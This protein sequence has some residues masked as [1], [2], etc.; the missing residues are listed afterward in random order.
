MQMAPLALAGLAT[1][2]LG[3]VL[4]LIL[5][6]LSAYAWGILAVGAA[7]LG[8]AVIL[9]F[10]RVKGALSSRRGR[11]SVGT[12]V[13]ASLFAGIILVAN[14]IS[15][16][17]Y[18]RFDFTSLAQFTLT[19]Q[20]KDVLAG[21]DKPVEVV[22]FFGS[23]VPAPVSSYARNLLAEYQNYSDRLT[24]RDVDPDLNPDQARQYQVDQ[25]GVQYGAAVFR[26]EG[27]QRQVYGP[28]ISGEAEHAFT[29][30]ILEVTGTR[31]KKVYFLTGHGEG[32]IGSTLDSARSGLRDDLFQVDTLDLLRTPGIPSDAA[33]LVVAGPR[34]PLTAGELSTLQG[35]LR[36]GGRMLLLMDPGAPQ[37]FRQLLAEWG[38]QFLDGSIVD[39]ASHVAP[40]PQTVLVSRTQNYFGLPQTYFPG[41]A[42]LQP[43]E[44]AREGVSVIPL[45]WSS[46]S[47]WIDRTV[48]SGVQPTFD[49]ATDLMGPW[50]VGALVSTG[51][52]DETS[53]PDG[54]R[55][56]VFSDSDFISNQHYRN[57]SNSG[58]FLTTMNWLA[59]GKEVV[60][61]D[62]KVLP[63]RPLVLNP[64]Q[65][66]F[67]LISSIGL[68]PLILLLAAGWIAWRRR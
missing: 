37:G 14:A 31:Q 23:T 64:E 26:S 68:L 34:G 45:V 44:E 56:A 40:N 43:T 16:G 62:R 47:S 8:A 60:S 49:A 29:S 28:Q 17:T 22:T 3:F 7:L 1:L 5:P 24:V 21:L 67:L 53:V 58:L 66:R 36:E 9:D 50:A 41:A 46:R 27:G 33:V 6:G 11:F 38:M 52:A 13:K 20:T 63:I 59:T 19:S 48:P 42:A 57:E 35:Y 61:M 30:A 51:S 55:L 25:L 4:R 15:V 18:H 39:P 10:R 65:V 54:M 2:F 32:D 12:T